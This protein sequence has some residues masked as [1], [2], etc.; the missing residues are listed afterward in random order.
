MKVTGVTRVT[1]SVGE[2]MLCVRACG[3][4]RKVEQGS[5]RHCNSND[6][7]GEGIHE[8]CESNGIACIGNRAGAE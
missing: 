7:I 6:P 5:S 3:L 8:Q 4:G 1:V 2:A